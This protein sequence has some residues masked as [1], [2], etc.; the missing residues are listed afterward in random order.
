M[1]KNSQ[2]VRKCAQ[3]VGSICGGL[4]IT[5][6]AIPQAAVAQQTTSKLNPCPR[7]FYEEPHNNRVLVPQGCPP[8][9]LTQ[10]LVA[11]GLIPISPVPSVPS[12]YQTGLG[13]GGEAP[14]AVNPNPSILNQPPYNRSQGSLQPEGSML[15]TPREPGVRPAPTRPPSSATQPPAQPQ[16]PI[17]MIALANGRVNIRLVNDTGANVTYQVIGDTPERSLP[18]KS[19]VML[20]GLTTP[21][22]VTFHR[23]DGGLLR[24][25]PQPS[26]KSGMLL[27]T[28]QQT[29]DV[30]Q[31][32][33][34]M[35]IQNN[36]SVF[37]N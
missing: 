33:S 31:D 26:S 34:A 12:P 17:T 18:S 30:N 9:A 21:T 22:T 19:N 36:G 5:L 1:N 23:Q 4:L 8:N 11:Q 24:V 13:V 37:L 15:P 16:A 28:L 3:L 6:P 14:S 35:R 29:T 27:V 10:R 2:N 25:T 32:R 20:R 7:I